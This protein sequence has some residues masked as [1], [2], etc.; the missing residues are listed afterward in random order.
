M[1][2]IKDATILITGANR[3]I[4]K[5]YA[6]GFAK[7]GAKKI[8]LGARN[9]DNVKD[10]VE[11][12][13]DVFVPLKLDV[14]S[15]AD[16][17]AAAEAA[18]D[19]D[20][21]VNNAGILFLNTLEDQDA[22]ANSRKEMD[23]NYFGVLA[24]TQAF[25]PILKK[26]GGGLI[27]T[28]SSIAGHVSFPGFM[29]YCASKYAVQSLIL[30]TRLYLADQGT[31]VIG[32]YPGPIDTD[33]TAEVPL[34]TFPVNVVPDTTIAAI[35]NGDDEVFTD[36]MSQGLYATFRQ[37]PKEIEKQMAE[38]MQEAQEEAA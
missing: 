34:D 22:I 7:E 17:K 26:N 5:A 31:R 4:G 12:N 9:P 21:L 6:E 2:T 29:T 18:Q 28:V 8:Y 33:M 35:K 38:M 36:E 15:D 10:M 20:V 19:V 37:D 25:A 13:P 27:I 30:S 24:M 14:T 1:N 16:I 23:V 32:V 3:G 11:S